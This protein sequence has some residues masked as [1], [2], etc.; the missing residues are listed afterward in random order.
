MKW[1]AVVVAAGRGTRLHGPKQL[2]DLAGLPMVGWSLKLFATVP[3]IAELVVATEPESLEPIRALFT[4]LAPQLAA[5]VVRGGATRQQSVFE[6]LRTLSPEMQGVLVH[7]GARPLVSVADVRAGICAVRAG[8]AALLAAPVVDTIKTVD[9]QSL[10]VGSTLERDTLW[11]AQTP[12]F[13]LTAD[14]REA[15]ERARRE[16]IEAT[17]DAALL[18]RMGIEVIVVPSTSENFKVTYPADVTRAES[19]LQQRSTKG[20][21]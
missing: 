15:H 5:R 1:A 21:G 16:G 11:A 17:D 12:Q 8:R 9:P 18:E 20:K 6:A 13:A 10:R 7:D 2:I 3:E 19:I 4:E 14:L